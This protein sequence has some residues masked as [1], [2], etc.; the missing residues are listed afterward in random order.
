MCEWCELFV[1][2]LLVF[3]CLLHFCFIAKCIYY[4]SRHIDE[5]PKLLRF[6][7]WRKFQFFKTAIG[8]FTNCSYLCDSL[9]TG[10]RV[11]ISKES[12]E[13][14]PNI[15]RTVE[16]NDWNQTFL[17]FYWITTC[18]GEPIA[19]NKLLRRSLLDALSQLL[20]GCI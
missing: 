13:Q 17:I 8:H 1:C 19:S 15:H 3:R 12:N 16:T 5:P 6:N 7:A 11:S 4:E 18:A 20:I 10:K 9:C 2:L 14:C